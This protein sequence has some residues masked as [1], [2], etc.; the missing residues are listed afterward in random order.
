VFDLD[1]YVIEFL[2][3]KVSFPDNTEIKFLGFE[4]DWTPDWT[5]PGVENVIKFRVTGAEKG[6]KYIMSEEDLIEFLNGIPRKA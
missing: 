5:Y 3:K 1:K 6:G 4:A 2:T